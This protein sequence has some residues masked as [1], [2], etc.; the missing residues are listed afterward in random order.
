MNA[1]LLRRRCRW[2]IGL[3]VA[4]LHAATPTWEN[5]RLPPNPSERDI[6]QY[7]IA[8]RTILNPPPGPIRYH[9][10]DWK[11]PPPDKATIQRAQDAL[12]EL[13]ASAIGAL[14]EECLRGERAWTSDRIEIYEVSPYGIRELRELHNATV[15]QRTPFTRLALQFIIRSPDIPAAQRKR[16]F[17]HLGHFP[18]LMQGITQRAWIKEMDPHV[19]PAQI[20]YVIGVTGWRGSLLY[21]ITALRRLDSAAGWQALAQILI[22]GEMAARFEVYR[23]LKEAP[24]PKV[25][26]DD[27]VARAW[28]YFLKQTYSGQRVDLAPLALA[29]GV[30]GALIELAETVLTPGAKNAPQA[31]D[32]LLPALAQN[33]PSAEAA[34]NFV[35]R[36]RRVLTF[37]R[38]A[39]K[40]DVKFP[41]R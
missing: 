25:D 21:W 5:L 14:L 38:V 26:L 17:E 36:N 3:I 8:L 27:C 20:R 31:G 16:V 24:T 15:S 33:F 6:T 32:L 13:P 2:A 39:G 7:L 22:E 28:K 11:L 9:P 12:D 19:T 18:E 30:Q 29:H 34:A 35:L 37:D 41:A 4:S 23:D 40:F 10:Q 1:A